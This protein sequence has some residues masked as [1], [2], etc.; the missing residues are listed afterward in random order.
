MRRAPAALLCTAF[1]A[2]GAFVSTWTHDLR[3]RFLPHCKRGLCGAA[4]ALLASLAFGLATATAA[5]RSTEA[6][7]T[8]APMDRQLL[9]MLPV[10]PPH[11]RP[12]TS[13]AGGYQ[14][15]PGRDVRRRLARK[16]AREHDLS[17]LE[18]WP[19][20]DL[21]L[22]CF[23]MQAASPDDKTRALP[24]LSADPR[25]AWAQPMQQMIFMKNISVVGGFLVLF[26]AGAG[27][28]SLDR[29]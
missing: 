12:D 9:V 1:P 2:C 22:D 23:V 25:V 26:A 3:T 4:F 5:E 10:P 6:S 11:F 7:T 8:A 21:G 24:R 18:D 29:A 28:W 17:L 16:L 27:R 20:P 15:A 13:Y 19:M 14:S